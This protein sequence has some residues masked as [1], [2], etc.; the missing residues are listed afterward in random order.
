MKRLGWPRPP[1]VLGLVVGAIFERY[2]FISAE[3]YGWGWLLRPAVMAILAGVAWALYRPVSQIVI[4]LV[5]EFKDVRTHRIRFGA[6]PTFTLAIVVLIVAAII[7]SQEWPHDAKLVPLTACGM[8]LV[9]ALLNL[10]NELFGS[11]Q[12]A[13]VRTHADSGV[14]VQ[15]EGFDFGVPPDVVRWRATYFFLWMAGFIGVVALI[16]FIPAIA[17]FVFAYMRFGFGEPVAAV[18]ALFGRNHGAVLGRVPLGA[19]S[20]GRIRSSG[21]LPTCGLGLA[22]E[23]LHLTCNIR[24]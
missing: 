13:A 23:L 8:A 16:G 1:M 14:N 24:G 19:G 9:A 11:E 18:I 6:A 4:S 5:H 3:L 2:L 17:V 10:V 21:M 22:V 12:A 20:L 7:S 15:A